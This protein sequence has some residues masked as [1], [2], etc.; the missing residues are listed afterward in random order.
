MSRSVFIY[1]H[2]VLPS[3]REVLFL[4]LDQLRVETH[5]FALF[6]SSLQGLT[7]FWAD[8]QPSDHFPRRSWRE[9]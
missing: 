7:H 5:A 3:C 6:Q 4:F 8:T 9:G 2:P 1:Y